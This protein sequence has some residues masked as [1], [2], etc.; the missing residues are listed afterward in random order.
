MYSDAYPCCESITYELI[1]TCETFDSMTEG[2]LFPLICL[3]LCPCWDLLVCVMVTA[4]VGVGICR[5]SVRGTF[6]S[7]FNAKSQMLS[8]DDSTTC[9]CGGNVPKSGNGSFDIRGKQLLPNDFM[10]I[11][12]SFVQTAREVLCTSSV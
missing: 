3:G 9:A 11:S 1:S 12:V 2:G 8:G 6:G 5:L 10:C 7:K 4:S